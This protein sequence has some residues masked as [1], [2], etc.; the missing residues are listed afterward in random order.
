MR[1]KTIVSR[2]FDENS[3][4]AH[5]EGKQECLVVDPGLEP[6][7][8]VRYLDSQQ[9]APA[10]ILNTHGH[11]DHIA[12]NAELK[13][14]WPNCPL[15][16]GRGD[17]DKLADPRLNLSAMFGG[18]VTSP[19]ADVLLA[20]GD[21]YCAAGFELFVAAIPGH[22][23]GHIVFIWKAAS[24]PVVFGG[25]VLFAGGIGRTDFPDGDMQQLT[26]GIHAKLFI[27]P[28]E[29]IVLPGHGPP[30]T[31]GQEKRDNPWV[32]LGAGYRPGA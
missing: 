27:L 17:A 2:P 15:A 5:L 14:R 18:Y 3:Y 10:A 20:D 7:A 16:I 31:I 22:S 12:G 13:A 30:T 26:A 25:D 11:S 24:P 19:P 9:L 4:I 28:D 6:D 23:A 29:T 21:V 8:I 32:G 1:L